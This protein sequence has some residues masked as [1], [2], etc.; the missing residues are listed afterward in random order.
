VGNYS[1]ILTACLIRTLAYAGVEGGSISILFDD[2]DGKY[3]SCQ[4]RKKEFYLLGYNI[5]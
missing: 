5:V 2:A 1:V 3:I 4:Q